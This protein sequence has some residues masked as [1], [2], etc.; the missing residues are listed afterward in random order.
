MALTK[1]RKEEV[2]DQYEKWLKESQS[3]V[4]TEYTG[5]N[6]AAMNELRGKIREVGGEFHVIKN[7]LAKRAFASAGLDA[8]DEYFLGS[9]A[10][11]IAFEDPTD[12]VKA[13]SDYSKET[14]FVI[15]KGG[16]MGDQHMTADEVK[17]LA[18]LPPMPV[19]RGQ[20]LGVLMAPASKLTRLLAEPGRQVAQVLKAYAESDAAAAAAEA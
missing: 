6:V 9:T 5:L 8:P 16:F 14:E 20:L 3:V 11:G 18:D 10:L 12:V 13:I 19:V 4:L 1:K 7:T 15:I 17:A 2:V